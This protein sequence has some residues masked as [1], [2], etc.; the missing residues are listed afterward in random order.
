MIILRRYIARNLMMSWLMVFLVLTAVF[1]LIGF[2]EELERTSRSYT[3]ASVVN[4]TLLT[5]PQKVLSLSPVVALLGTIAALGRM[6]VSNELLIISCSGVPLKQLLWAVIKP[7]LV[8]MVG[9]W[10]CLEYVAAPMHQYGEQQRNALRSNNSV[11][12]PRG[13]VWS[14]SGHRYIHLGKMLPGYTP[15]DIDLYEF[16][17]EGKLSLH[18]HAKSAT[19]HSGRRWVFN[20][21]RQKELVN[22]TLRTRYKKE[23]EILNL[24]SKRELPSLTLSSESMPL[25][26]LY[27]Y[28]E[29]LRG[30]DRAYGQYASAFWQRLIMPLTVAAMVLLATPISA[31][32]G[33]MRSNSFGITIGIGSL[34]GLLFYVGAQIAFAL[35][36]VLGL[37]AALVTLFPTV[38]VA[39]FATF[40]LG[41]MRW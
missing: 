41:K 27:Q 18:L 11:V 19:V 17:D 20:N 31:S 33:S 9:L 23:V 34:V 10:L 39:A 35:G 4:Y 37:Q 7:T 29:Y 8:L 36:Q 32:M 3:V 1:G 38:V 28:S 25:T 30:I 12:I 15:G 22:N 2:I 13:G 5:L 16:N 26:V 40:L 21:V 24:W 14:K 6:Q